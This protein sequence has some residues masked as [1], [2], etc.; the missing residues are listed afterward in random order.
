MQEELYHI[1]G[2]QSRVLVGNIDEK[3]FS[4]YLGHVKV[5]PIAVVIVLN[6]REVSEVVKLAS[7]YKVPIIPRGSGTGLTGGTV[8]VE[9]SLVIDLSRLNQ[10]EKLDEETLTLTVGAGILLQDIQHFVEER[11]LF[12]PPDPGEK[13]AT[14]GGNIATNAGGMRAVKYGVTR[15]YI[16]S[17]EV[18]LANGDIVEIGSNTIKNSSGLNIKDLIIGSEGTLGIVTKAHL[19]VISKPQYVKSCLVAFDTLEAA[20]QTV[21]QIIRANI[22]ITALEFIEKEAVNVSASYLKLDFPAQ[23]GNAY[24]L[25][26][27]DGKN[28]DYI[29]Q[30]YEEVRAICT[31]GGALDFIVL[32][33]DD[34][35]NTWKIR[36]AI[37]TA[38]EARS[39][40]EPIDVVVPINQIAEF[41][42]FTKEIAK[43]LDIEIQS[44]GHAGDGNVHLCI[45]RGELSAK[46]WQEK[47]NDVL[48]AIY[49]KA[50]ALDGLPSGEHG[51]GLTKLKYYLKHANQ[52][53]IALMK[54]IKYAFDPKQLL[55]PGKAF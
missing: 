36:G 10:I 1:I 54:E 34:L 26:T 13:T 5:K 51:I 35:E 2:D 47:L 29:R 55:N 16:R 30:N 12:Y 48:E 44:F 8:P 52:T 4:D 19:K 32:E 42:G 37:V 49:E 43:Q 38:I 23:K 6:T 41:V 20:V 9:G 7:R 25:L 28:V 3:Y 11:G 50:H 39:E 15:D 14:I 24:L 21:P 27:F 22:D 46:E 45:I 40:Q 53:E 17:L 31:Q 33:E 18:V